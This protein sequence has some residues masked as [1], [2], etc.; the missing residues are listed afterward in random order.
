MWLCA[1]PDYLQR[2]GP[3]SQPTSLKDHLL[4]SYYLSPHSWRFRD[5][6]GVLA[7][8]LLQAGIAVDE[9]D[10]MLEML[11][12]GA[13]IG[14]LPDFIAS[15]SVSRDQL[16]RLMPDCDFGSLPVHA[17]YPSHRSL[18]PKVRA[19]IDALAAHLQ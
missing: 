11:V 14:L 19:F 4:I 16:I 2:A 15:A 1:S 12:G 7:D 10:A 13:G 6:G 9:P 5:V 18:M 8:V 3:V 17:L